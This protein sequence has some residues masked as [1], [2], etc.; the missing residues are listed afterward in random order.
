[1]YRAATRSGASLLSQE[2]QPTCNPAA[3]PLPSV[4]PTLQGEAPPQYGAAA[5]SQG[6]DQR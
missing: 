1:M 6:A 2:F 3:T 5:W 4:A